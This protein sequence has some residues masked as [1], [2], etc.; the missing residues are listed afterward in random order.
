M[1]DVEHSAISINHRIDELCVFT[2]RTTPVRPCGGIPPQVCTRLMKP[3]ATFFCA[4]FLAAAHAED[5]GK[6]TVGAYNFTRPADWKTVEPTSPM[7]K[8]QLQI[9]GKDGGKPAEITFF[10]FGEG[11]GGGVEPNVQRWFGQFTANP[12]ANKVEKQEF[13]GVKVT[14]VSTD[15]TL[16]AS[17]M[18]G[19]AAEQP[20]AALLGAILEH[21]EGAVFVK[22]TGPAPLVKG[23]RE[24]FLALIKSATEKK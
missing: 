24:Q 3:L 8:A 9:P 23:S 21:P 17:P 7:R 20:N 14:L 18:A 16:K 10:F 19:I 5:S 12:D 15:G 4:V 13:N 22:M 6:F 1:S 11:N 2:L